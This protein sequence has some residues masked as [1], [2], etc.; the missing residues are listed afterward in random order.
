MSSCSKLFV[1][2]HTNDVSYDTLQPCVETTGD[3]RF[4]VKR[5]GKSFQK[6]NVLHCANFL[7]L[8]ALSILFIQFLAKFPIILCRKTGLFDHR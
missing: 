8:M 6:T 4:N 1:D 3:R 2:R 7:L 5:T